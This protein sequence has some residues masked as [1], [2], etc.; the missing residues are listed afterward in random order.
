M[1]YATSEDFMQWLEDKKRK[2]AEEPIDDL[3]KSILN[4][5]NIDNKQ[6]DVDGDKKQDNEKDINSILEDIFNDK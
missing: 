3:V 2:E 4:D 1:E 6:G 5:T